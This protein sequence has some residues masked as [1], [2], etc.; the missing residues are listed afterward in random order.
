MRIIRALKPALRTAAT[1][2]S[3]SETPTPLSW[4]ALSDL[5]A[6]PTE[7]INNGPT[8][9]RSYARLFGQDKKS[10]KVTLYRDYHAWCPYCQKVWLFLEEK[11]IPFFV[12]KITMFCYGE[13][14]AWY[15][16]IVPSGM[17]PALDINGRIITESDAILEAL[18]VEFGPL[19]AGLEAPRVV[20]IRRL[21]RH[22]FR[23]WCQWLC[24]PSRSER[25]EKE[26]KRYFLEALDLISDSLRSVP[27]P[28]FLEDFSVADI[29]ITPYIERMNASIY[30]YK[31][32]S[33]RD[34]YPTIDNWFCAMET[35]Q[36]YLGTQSDF[37]THVFDLPPQMGGCHALGSPEQ[38]SFM[39]RVVNGPWFG[40]PDTRG[41]E[42]DTSLLEAVRRVSKHHTN[43][44]ETNIDSDKTRVD[45]ALRCAL[46]NLVHM[47]DEDFSHPPAGSALALRYLRDHIS[48]PR[49]MSIY[50]AKHL[51]TTLEHT[52]AMAGTEQ[53]PPIPTKNRLDQDPRQ[54]NK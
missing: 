42:P 16:K 11:R 9:P 1:Q 33:I 10:V 2:I 19:Y 45:I 54:F 32:F 26:N 49:D 36:T 3:M 50:A 38:L 25:A 23:A 44:I 31:G 5:A 53:P 17:L 8:N 15:K 13:K 22:L 46:T 51:K 37:H 35:R 24:Y 34:E 18:E 39:N 21:E 47:E 12:K 52:A 6:A 20:A 30:A 27:G 28:Y 43:I 29:I 40:L 4:A 41:K 7:D 48:V 14:E